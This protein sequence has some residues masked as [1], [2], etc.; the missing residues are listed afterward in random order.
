MSENP[1]KIINE[2]VQF[3]KAANESRTLTQAHFEKALTDMEYTLKVAPGDE[4]AIEKARE[5]IIGTAEALVD[6]ILVSHRKMIELKKRVEKLG[7]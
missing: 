3:Q 7:E 5:Q 6:A 2:I 4:V 1:V